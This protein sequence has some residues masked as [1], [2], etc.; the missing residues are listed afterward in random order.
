VAVVT[1]DKGIA[2]EEVGR[3][4]TGDW[5]AGILKTGGESVEA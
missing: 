4:S 1:V 2:A 3:G 5:G